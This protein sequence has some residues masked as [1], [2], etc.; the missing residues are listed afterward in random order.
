MAHRQPITVMEPM[1][2]TMEALEAGIMQ[3]VK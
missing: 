2:I 1:V 3:K